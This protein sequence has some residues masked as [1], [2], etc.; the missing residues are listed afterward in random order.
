MTPALILSKSY[1]FSRTY[2]GNPLLNTLRRHRITAH[3]DHQPPGR[4]CPS[5]QGAFAFL[6]LQAYRPVRLMLLISSAPL[7]A[8]GLS[9]G[10]WRRR[11]SFHAGRCQGHTALRCLISSAIS[12]R[13]ATS[14]SSLTRVLGGEALKSFTELATSP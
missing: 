2:L 5:L 14:S 7:S 9:Q 13:A 8:S 3:R 12:S 6:F 10:V 4:A 1:L 11:P